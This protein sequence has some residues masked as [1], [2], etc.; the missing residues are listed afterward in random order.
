MRIEIHEI[1]ETVKNILELLDMIY[2]A[3][4]KEEEEKTDG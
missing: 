4:T 2:H 1:W 3:I